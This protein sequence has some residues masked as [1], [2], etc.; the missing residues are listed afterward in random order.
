MGFKATAKFRSAPQPVPGF[1][2][3][4]DR[5]VAMK[6]GREELEALL[7]APPKLATVTDD[8]TLAAMAQNIFRAG[9]VWKIVEAKWPAFEEVFGG[10]DIM[11]V[12]SMDEDDLD[13]IASDARIIRNRS[14][15]AAVRDN[16]RFIF[17]VCNEH[18]SF[19]SYLEAWPDED[20]VGLWAELH[21][22]GSRLGGFTRSV[23]L[24]E[25]GKDT[26]MFSSDVVRALA[27]AG[28][29]DKAPTSKRD[30]ARVQ[31]AFNTWRAETGRTFTELSKIMAYSMG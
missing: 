2:T 1:A 3:I 18:G 24:R 30:L 21:K 28:V 19:A 8:R 20:L 15:V 22:R 11:H 27:G 10:F 6:G 4:Y 13:R 12:A 25:V 5:A 9:F 16:A 7:P 26:F 17:E 14:K 29:V 23:F 31:A